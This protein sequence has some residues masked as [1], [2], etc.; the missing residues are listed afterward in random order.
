MEFDYSGIENFLL[1][2]FLTWADGGRPLPRF[3]GTTGD[4]VDVFSY[5]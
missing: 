1:G 3:L 5:K 4:S 2:D